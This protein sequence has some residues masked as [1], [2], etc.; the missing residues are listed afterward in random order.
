MTRYRLRNI[1]WET[2]GAS[3]VLPTEFVVDCEDE[4][5]IADALSDLHGWLVKGF[6]VEGSTALPVKLGRS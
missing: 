4:A 3:P 5:D 6:V 1:E 2:D